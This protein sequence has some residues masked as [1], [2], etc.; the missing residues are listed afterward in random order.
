MLMKPTCWSTSIRRILLVAALFESG[1]PVLAQEAPKPAKTKGRSLTDRYPLVYP[2]TLADGRTSVVEETAEFLKPGPNLREGVEIAKTPPRVE[3][4]FYPEQNYPGN[5]WSH[6]SDGFVLGDKYYSSSNDHLAPRGTAHLWEYD[7][8]T[9]KFR[10]LCDT[11]KFLE[12]AG[13]FPESMNYRP[14]EMQSRIDLG[15]DGWLYYATDR[16]SPTVTNDAHGYLGEWILRTHPADAEDGDRR[17]ASD[18][19]AHDSRQRARSRADDPL[20]RHGAGQGFAESER[21]VLRAGSEEPQDPQGRRRRPDADADLLALDRPRVLGREDVRSADERDHAGQRAARALLL[22]GDAAGNRVRHVG[23]QGRPVVACNV[24]TGEVQAARLRRGRQA[25]VHL[26]DRGRSDRPLPVLRARRAWR[27]D[28]GRH[29]DRAVRHADRQEE[30]AGLPARALLG[31]STATPW[32]ARSATPWTRKGSGSSSPGTAGARA[33][34][35]AGNRP[36]SPCCTSRPRS[37]AQ[38]S[39]PARSTTFDARTLF[40]TS[41]TAARSA[42]RPMAVR[43]CCEQGVLIEDDG[44]AAG[45]SYQ[46]NEE[47]LSEGVWIKKELWI[48]QPAARQATLLV[49]RQPGKDPQPLEAT[50]NGHAAGW[51]PAGRA[52]RYCEAYRIDPKL[53]VPGKNEIVLQRQRARSGSPATTNTPPA[54]ASA[55]GIPIAA[56]RAPTAARPGTTTTWARAATSTASTTCDCSWTSLIRAAR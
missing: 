13:A 6:R 1:I 50:I 28:Q 19:Q 55:R 22:A 2:P 56:P 18:R 12:S 31:A 26:L 44:P 32:T 34:R 23:N 3:F 30:G 25:G 38:T 16:G 20:L 37:E 14:G 8:A 39:R 4:S 27:R 35:A 36:R 49:G 24:K 46:P 21:A 41:V 7:A 15:S 29:A 43:S 47:L 42:C 11:T 48:E 5:P 33:S 10:L 17:H 53:L 45:Y 54:R 9:R 51:K 52:G 40:D